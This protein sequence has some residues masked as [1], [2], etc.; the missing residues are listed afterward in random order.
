[1]C[2]TCMHTCTHAYIHTGTRTHTHTHTH[3]HTLSFSQDTIKLTEHDFFGMDSMD[4]HD[5]GG[6]DEVDGVPSRR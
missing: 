5:I 1:M 2:Y 6:K 4:Y 3:T